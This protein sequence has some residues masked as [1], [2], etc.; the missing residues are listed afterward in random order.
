MQESFLSRIT[1]RRTH[2]HTAD[3]IEGFERLDEKHQHHHSHHT[4]EEI[5]FNKR[6]KILTSLRNE[7]IDIT[8]K[9]MDY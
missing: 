9:P 2:S 8:K 1:F 7:L 4:Q 5:E 6:E 3:N